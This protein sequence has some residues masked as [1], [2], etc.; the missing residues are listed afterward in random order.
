MGRRTRPT[1]RVGRRASS[2]FSHGDGE[3]VA[4]DT[5]NRGRCCRVSILF[6]SEKKARK[7]R[8]WVHPIVSQ[9]LLKGAFVTLYSELREHPR[10]FF[11]YFRM[12]TPTFDELYVKLESK[13]IHKNVV[14]LSISATERLCVALR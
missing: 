1:S 8:F 11:N 3:A 7:R 12:S 5:V 4:R 13:L 2:F 9:T 6:N 14:R 10:I